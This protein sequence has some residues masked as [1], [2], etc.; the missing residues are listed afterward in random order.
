[1]ASTNRF[2]IPSDPVNRV[3]AILPNFH[4][5]FYTNSYQP[6]VEYEY[7]VTQRLTVTAG[8]KYAY[9]N[10]NLTQYQD[11][12]K[13]V[14]CLGGV[15]TSGAGITKANETCVG[16]SPTTNHSAGYSSY[17]PSVDAN[18]HLR[19]NWSVYAQYGMGTIIPPSSVF[20]VTGAVV[21]NTPKP[22]GVNTYQAGT[23]FKLKQLT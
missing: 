19:N 9:F 12:G 20:D 4:E 6:F 23:V 10:Q 15:L 3:D 7:H 11:N 16:G 8:F 21:V 17:L 22:T 13:I 1:M 18:Y 14:G 2:Q 5:R